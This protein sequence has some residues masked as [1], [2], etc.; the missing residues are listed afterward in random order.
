VDAAGRPTES[1][2]AGNEP[3]KR[4]RDDRE[5]KSVEYLG[6]RK[7]PK[8]KSRAAADDDDD[9]GSF[10]SGYV[11]Q[12]T[13]KEKQ[14]RKKKSPTP[15]DDRPHFS[16]DPAA[17][18]LRRA[19]QDQ[20]SVVFLKEKRVEADEKAVSAKPRVRPSG[21]GDGDDDDSSG[22]DSDHSHRGD[23][24][25][26]GNNR[27][28][29]GRDIDIYAPDLIQN[30]DRIL[31]DDPYWEDD[32]EV[33]PPPLRAEDEQGLPPIQ[34][35]DVSDEYERALTLDSSNADDDGDG[36]IGGFNSGVF[37]VKR[38][39]DGLLCVEKRLRAR[40]VFSGRYLH[41]IR[42]TQ[43]LRHHANIVGYIDAFALPA[44]RPPAA[45]LYI[46]Y[47][48]IGSLNGFVTRQ[49]D[50]CALHYRVNFFPEAFVW[51]VLRSLAAALV[52][53]RTG[54]TH[55]SQV[56]PVPGWRPVLHRDIKPDN[57]FLRPAAAQPQPAAPRAGSR[58]AAVGGRGGA[59]SSSGAAGADSAAPVAYPAVALGDFGHSMY[60][61][62][63]PEEAAMYATPIL[64][65]PPEVPRQDVGGRTDVWSAGGVAKTVA[66][67]QQEFRTGTRYD[68]YN[69]EQPA[70]ERYSRFL[71]Q[72]L[73]VAMEP[74]VR[75]RLDACQFFERV[76]ALYEEAQP[77]ARPIPTRCREC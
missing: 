33:R 2:R 76:N 77:A 26:D 25:G 18:P 8:T 56:R 55:P 75:Q 54:S 16:H 39:R 12:R 28:E 41:E 48:S 46:P 51:H 30:P 66:N 17:G 52:H 40:D 3:R 24:G 71:N 69:D 61:P 67:L 1:S 21:D 36:N 74:D 9:D 70:G 32:E 73:R 34:Q 62:D 45:S 15:E 50:M 13:G 42:L 14:K 49:T 68:V 20:R 53:L 29:G 31:D 37:V 35:R 57:V 72:A 64:R 38:R 4:R 6:T 63:N 23:R 19:P 11:E 22:D 27:D 10:V 60:V 59:S 47:F 44:A 5:D 65:W 58:G 43:R 7:K